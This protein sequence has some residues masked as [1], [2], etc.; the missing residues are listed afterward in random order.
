MLKTA[1]HANGSP[2][3]VHLG[4]WKKQPTDTRDEDYRL[5]LPSGVFG[6]APASVDLRSICSP[7]EDQ[8]DL[9]SC[10]ANM[11][12]GMVEAN[13]NRGLAKTSLAQLGAATANVSVSN[14]SVAADGTITFTTTIKTTSAPTPA[15]TP[16]PSP[17]PTPAK[18]VQV[19]RLFEYYATRKIEGTV[20]E[21]S[22]ATIRDTVKAAA[23]YGVVDEASWPYNISKF[24]TN[25]PA[26]LWTTAL[27]HKVTS[28]HSIADGD[29]ATMK[30]TLAAG[31]L[32]GYGFQ[33]YSYFMSA[34]MAKNGFLNIPGKSET[35]QGGHAQCLVGYD[36]QM[37]NPFNSASKGAFLVRNS[38]GSAWGLAGYYWVSYD[39]LKNTKLASDFWVIQSSAF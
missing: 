27:T 15:P 14:V 21:D 30:A 9:G 8:G 17:T 29:L 22:G 24:A 19:S 28:Y 34:D 39:Y 26:A 13:E 7:V 4:G 10:T 18:L 38:W 33:V 31:Y 35:L 1:H 3:Q 2:R 37:V 32:V 16:S 23:Q 20:S 6:A 5:K 11:L 25:P 12:A 36:D